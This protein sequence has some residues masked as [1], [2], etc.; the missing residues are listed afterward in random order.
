LLST[1]GTGCLSTSRHPALTM[2]PDTILKTST[3]RAKHLPCDWWPSYWGL[4]LLVR[5][6]F[7][8]AAT[9]AM[10]FYDAFALIGSARPFELTL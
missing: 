1:V 10:R 6:V 2:E 4:V 9:A 3:E 7:A 5:A 8:V